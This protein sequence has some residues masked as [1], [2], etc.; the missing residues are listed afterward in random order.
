VEVVDEVMVVAT[1]V[2]VVAEPLVVREQVGLVVEVA[3]QR[4]L[5][6]ALVA[7]V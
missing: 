4:V 6:L 1:V 5:L 3:R 7:V 2:M